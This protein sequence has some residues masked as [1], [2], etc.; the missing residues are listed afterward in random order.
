MLGKTKKSPLPK[1]VP[2]NE[3]PQLF[4]NSFLD[5]TQKIRH[6]L[7]T[8]KIFDDF[9]FFKGSNF[10]S[11]EHVSESDVKAIILDSP[12]KHCELDPLPSSLLLSC[13]DEI[14]PVVT[15][16]INQSLDDGIVPESFKN[17]LVKPLLKK[18]SLDQENFKNYRPVSN[19]PFLSKILEKVVLKQLLAHLKANNLVEPFQSAYRAHHSTETA[20]L[21]VVNDIFLEVDDRKLVMLNL[22]DLSAAFDTIDHEILLRRLELTFGINGSVLKWFM[23]YLSDR[24]QTVVVGN[25]KSSKCPLNYGVPQG[26]VLGP[27]L[28]TIYTQP[29]ARVIRKFNVSYHFYADDTQIYGSFSPH[30]SDMFFHNIVQCIQEVKVWMDENRL[31][32]NDDKTEIILF[33]SDKNLKDVNKSSIEIGDTCI[34]FAPFVKNLG[35]YLDSNLSMSKQISH[36]MKCVYL[37]LKRIGHIRHFISVD[38]AQMLATSL[39]M[40]RLDYCN[41][42]L[43]GITHD[44]MKKLKVAQNNAARVVLRRKKRDHASPL[45]TKLHWL[46]VEKRIIY[47]IATLSHRCLN[48]LAPSY[49]SELLTP[50]T[51][52]RQLRSSSGTTRLIVPRTKYRVFGERRFACFAPKIW[53]SL[54]KSIRE[55]KTVTAFKRASKTHLFTL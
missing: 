7:S 34:S 27:V 22:L 50:Y 31:K 5:K 28:F 43:T 39:I 18:P 53:N 3:L 48:G 33:G 11:F 29:L 45:L 2:V 1:T 20:L 38:I 54:P 49:L 37:D 21:R 16:I 42:I 44:L 55:A 4:A 9:E 23:S 30:D 8:C 51:P 47:K 10:T 15:T 12:R 14:I 6:D 24:F 40:S 41:S 32:L 52:S 25:V 13:I 26:S 36:V 35:I 46:P 17:A 19:L